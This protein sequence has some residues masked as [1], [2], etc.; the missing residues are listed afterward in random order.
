MIAS[1]AA[2]HLRDRYEERELAVPV[3]RRDAMY[4]ALGSEREE[5]GTRRAQE[6]VSPMCQSGD[7]EGSHLV[8]LARSLY[9]GS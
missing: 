2:R 4:I 6:K 5:E 1:D 9:W 8:S 3:S 7:L